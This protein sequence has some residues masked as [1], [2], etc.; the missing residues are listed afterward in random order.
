MSFVRVLI[1]EDD[2][3]LRTTLTSALQA[4][5]IEVVAATALAR[6]AV[7]AIKR[8]GIDVALIDLDLGPGP[9]GMDL[10]YMM[11]KIAP[12]I[13]IIFVT[14]YSDPRLIGNATQK[15][16]TGARYITKS[17]IS[18]MKQLIEL[19]RQ[20]YRS[21]L[22]SSIGSEL[23][24]DE[25]LTDRQ[26][27]IL[28]LVGQGLSTVE[29]SRILD[30]SEKTVE[31]AISRLNSSLGLRKSDGKNLRV[32]LVRAYFTLTGKKPPRD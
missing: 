23:V 22:R 7:D 25:S 32:Q 19:I 24:K 6:E 11:R 20:V 30:V 31:A 4:R 9:T 28:R 26:I 27:E 13:G 1:V 2:L 15:M 12:E 10:A 14:S 18:D 3:Y 17:T 29:I 8:G 21:P 5:H 16:P